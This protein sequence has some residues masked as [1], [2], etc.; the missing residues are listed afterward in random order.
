M[1]TVA[2]TDFCSSFWSPLMRHPLVSKT[3][4]CALIVI[5][6]FLATPILAV[7]YP[8]IDPAY[9]QEIYTGPLTGGPGMAWTSSNNLLTRNGSTI[10]EYSPTQNTTYKAT[11]LHGVIASHPITGLDG[12]GVGMTNGLDGYIYAVGSSGLQRFD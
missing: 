8:T 11:S 3:M 6:H 1:T 2:S 10:L 4:L 7:Q 5:G 12:S 9:T